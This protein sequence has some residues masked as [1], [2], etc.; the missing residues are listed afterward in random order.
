VRNAQVHSQV[1]CTAE[2]L[3]WLWALRGV[4]ERVMVAQCKMVAETF[5]AFAA[6]VSREGL[7][8]VRAPGRFW[9]QSKRREVTFVAFCLKMKGYMGCEGQ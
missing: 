9:S 8:V 3:K 7:D 6:R 4:I 2:G 5:V 1:A